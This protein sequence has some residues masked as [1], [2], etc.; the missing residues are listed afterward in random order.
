MYIL[1][2]FVIFISLLVEL[3]TRKIQSGLFYLSYLLMTL[4]VV[5]R[6]G[7][8]TDYFGYMFLYNHVDL[9]SP[10]YQKDIGFSL[11]CYWS[12][13]VGMSYVTFSS[14][15]ALVTMAI[16]FPFF[17]NICKKSM[18]PVFLFYAYIFLIYP[19]SGIRQG[20]TLAILLGILYPLLIRKKYIFYYLVL[21][22]G[23]SIHGSLL[24]CAIIPFI[25]LINFKKN[26]AILLFLIATAISLLNI[27]IYSILPFALP[28][29]RGVI[30]DGDDAFN[31]TGK[32]FRIIIILIYLS[33]PVKYYKGHLLEL[34]N[35]VFTG[36]LIYSL[37]S[38]IGTVAARIEIYF[39][40]FELL[41]LYLL[42]YNT[43]I[44]KT[45]KYYFMLIVLYSVL[46]FKNIKSQI[47]QGDYVN[48]NILSYPFIS[49]FN[50]EKIKEVRK[51]D[52]VYLND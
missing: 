51:D 8:G 52:A 11:L 50:P 28:Q 16:F 23:S 39:R 30:L 12:T 36:Y 31:F 17:N 10:V 44:T 38:F 32:I 26:I 21:F 25:K 7:Q 34:R 41:L 2:F 33:I 29:N 9:T 27:N 19:A 42:L 22:L 35:I 37:L 40:A 43:F 49:I 1:L 5:F 6:Y 18:M 3:K 20:L 48:T 45:A 46:F 13:N 47:D 14:L 15:F 4:I 24:I